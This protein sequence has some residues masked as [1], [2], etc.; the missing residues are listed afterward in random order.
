MFD[1]CSAL[2]LNGVVDIETKHSNYF[3]VHQHF[4]V[5]LFVPKLHCFHK[6][7]H[8]SERFLDVFVDFF[9]VLGDELFSFL[10]GRVESLKDKVSLLKISNVAHSRV[11]IAL[12]RRVLWLTHFVGG[13]VNNLSFWIKALHVS[14]VNWLFKGLKRLLELLGY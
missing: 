8:S 11:Q 12:L 13:K 7:W 9:Q 3:R 1:V 6:F 4:E 14:K 2:S 10:V 5:C